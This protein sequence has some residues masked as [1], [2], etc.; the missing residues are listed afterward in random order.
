M[1]RR[2]LAFTACFAILFPSPYSSPPAHAAC[3]VSGGSSSRVK[4]S[5][6][7]SSYSATVCGEAIWKI[8]P[9]PSKPVTG[10]T[11]TRKWNNKIVVVPDRPVAKVSLSRLSPNQ[12]ATFQ[13][14][15]IRHTRN[16]LLL[17]FPAQV[18]FYP[19]TYSWSFG[20]GTT[21][22]S[23]ESQHWFGKRGTFSASVK[24]GFSV[25]YRIIGQS[26]WV[27]LPGLV[28]RKSLPIVVNVSSLPAP[29]TK[30]PRL[31]HFECRAGVQIIG[32]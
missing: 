29:S 10:K 24:V 16:R 20:D 4:Y 5:G 11:P 6:S 17:W 22:S 26:G 13:A 30:L 14:I 32:C 27:A 31:V 21:A 15:S 3:A 8:I 1:V 25:R 9:R 28:F 19:R 18:R 7:L 2:F 23:V 12:P